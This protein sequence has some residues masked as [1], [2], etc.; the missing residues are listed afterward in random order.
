M[1]VSKGKSAPNPKVLELSWKVEPI[2]RSIIALTK[3]RNVAEDAGVKWAG[4]LA[5]A[6]KLGDAKK[7]SKFSKAYQIELRK[8]SEVQKQI[9][10]LGAELNKLALLASKI[11]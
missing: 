11:A 7:V 5:M 9:T 3:R 8:A 10:R 1:A 4:E 2:R 6:L